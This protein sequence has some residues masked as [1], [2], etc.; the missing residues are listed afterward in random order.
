MTDLSEDELSISGE[1]TTHPQPSGIQCWREGVTS[2]CM[3][4][5]LSPLETFKA[6]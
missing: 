5:A 1:A 3:C 2:T 6:I 4:T